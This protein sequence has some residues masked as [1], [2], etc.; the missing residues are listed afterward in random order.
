MSTPKSPHRPSYSSTISS[1]SETARKPHGKERKFTIL[2]GSKFHAYGRDKAPYPLPFD[3]EVLELWC[4][5]HALIIQACS[6]V[7]FVDFKGN[8]PKRCLDLGTGLGDWTVDAAKRWPDC[9]FVGFDL[10][11]VQIPLFTLHQSIA[12]RIEWVH[13]NFL[14]AKLP[15]EDDEF[16]HIR[17]QGISFGIPENK[18]VW[19]YE[20][21]RRVLKHGGTIEHL[22]ADAIF[23]ILPR[24]FT[25]PLHART[26]YMSPSSAPLRSPT[27][28]AADPVCTSHEYELLEKLFYEVFEN[29]FINP[30]ASA[31]LPRYFSAVFSHVVSPPVLTFPMPPLAPLE[32]LPSQIGAPNGISPINANANFS[33]QPSPT[34]QIDTS[35]DVLTSSPSL[36]TPEPPSSNTNDAPVTTALPDARPEDIK[37]SKRPPS[38]ASTSSSMTSPSSSTSSVVPSL[39]SSPSTSTSSACDE[40]RYSSTSAQSERPVLASLNAE[41]SSSIGGVELFPMKELSNLDEHSL[42]MQLYR[43]A[44]VVFATKEAMW[45]ELAEKVVKRD[46]SLRQYGWGDNDYHVESSRRKFESLMVSYKTDMKVRMA[47]WNS[48]VQNGWEYP[49]RDPLSKA[50]ALEEERLRQD[51]LEARRL[52]K[53]KELTAFCRQIRLAIGVN[54]KQ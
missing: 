47:L 1:S 41:E 54:I 48:L 15:F 38:V 8:T 42:Y 34:L 6:N 37:T 20:E 23:P 36:A 21:L 29:R 7:S 18:W 43:A 10:V 27:T 24:W 49:R 46:L 31:I 51:I 45:E 28:P 44:M 30:I 53:E 25:E 9:T 35:E 22:E 39:T 14:R 52:A 16:D 19:L 5:D 40:P 32:P 50:E 13:G 33:P 3:R 2:N 11:D 17:I 12:S 26:R 4:I